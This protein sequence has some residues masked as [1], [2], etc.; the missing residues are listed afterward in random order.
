M[1]FHNLLA[2]NRGSHHNSSQF[3][4]I[5]H[6]GVWWGH[7]DWIFTMEIICGDSDKSWSRNMPGVPQSGWVLR[8]PGGAFI[9]H[10]GAQ[11][12]KEMLG[13]VA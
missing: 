7:L 12:E 10:V 3:I 5:H 2:H 13:A 8:P 4:T 1:I 6:N 9:D 11:E